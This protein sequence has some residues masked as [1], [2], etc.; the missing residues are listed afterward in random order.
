MRPN[1]D[2]TVTK[3]RAPVTPGRGA[4]VRRHRSASGLLAMPH[5]LTWV[6]NADIY[7]T[8]SFKLYTCTHMHIEIQIQI[9]M[10]S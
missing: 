1:K 3:V 7:T 4:V 10:K 5:L 9:I 8:C 6:E 2:T